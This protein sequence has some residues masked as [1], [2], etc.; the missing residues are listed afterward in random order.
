LSA[1]KLPL[2]TEYLTLIHFPDNPCYHLNINNPPAY[3]ESY[4]GLMYRLSYLAK[5]RTKVYSNEERSF[6]CSQS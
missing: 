1:L 2:A 6:G 5:E 4:N 3:S